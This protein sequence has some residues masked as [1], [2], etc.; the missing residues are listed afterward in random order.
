M[1][2]LL[3]AGSLGYG[4]MVSGWAAGSLIGSLVARRV[5]ARRGE[6]QSLIWGAGSAAVALG[7]I[8]AARWLASAA[9]LLALAGFLNSISAVA[10]ETIVQRSTPDAVRSRVMAAQEGIWIAALGIGLGLG[11]LVLGVIGPRATYVVAGALGLA[12][13]LVLASAAAAHA[14]AD[15]RGAYGQ[16]F[17]RHS[18]SA[19][20][21]WYVRHNMAQRPTSPTRANPTLEQVRGSPASPSP[22][23]HGRHRRR[24]GLARSPRPG[25]ARH[26]GARLRAG[27]AGPRPAPRDHPDSRYRG[28]LAVQPAARRGVQARPPRAAARRLDGA[29]VRVG[30]R[31]RGGARRRR[32]ARAVGT[33]GRSWWPRPRASHRRDA[34]LRRRDIRV[35]FFGD[36]PPD[37]RQ[38]CVCVDDHGGSRLLT[39][40]LLQLGHRRIGVLCGALDGSSSIDR[41]AGHLAALERR[42]HRSDPDLITAYDWTLPGGR[43]AAAML[44]DLPDP[45]TAILAAHPVLAAGAMLELRERGLQIPGDV[46]GV[47]LQWTTSVTSR[48]RSPA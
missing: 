37:P 22:P 2:R 48:R 23:P 16:D 35:V 7:A 3:G 1:A 20:G 30:R 38:A 15:C 39:E 24:P 5:V 25:G 11:G 40:H 46:A 26:R 34:L 21:T 42:R 12:G 47:V 28:A 33:R 45:P 43:A 19:E 32:G 10:E 44:L 4:I 27:R 14:G 9:A 6:L 29:D 18:E 8:G 17:A 41:R 13:S 31:S 36:R